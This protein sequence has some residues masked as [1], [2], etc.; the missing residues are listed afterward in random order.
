MSLDINL[1][2]VQC[3]LRC[4]L[5]MCVCVCVF[6]AIKWPAKLYVSVCQVVDS[7]LHLKIQTEQEEEQ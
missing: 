7:S 5:C 2:D 4:A 3:N 1:A 6:Q